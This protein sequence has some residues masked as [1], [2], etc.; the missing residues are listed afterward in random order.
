[1]ISVR[2]RSGWRALVRRGDV[3]ASQPNAAMPINSVAFVELGAKSL[4]DIVKAQTELL[5]KLQDL[6]RKW[7]DCL[8][9][10]ADI[11]SEFGVKFTTARSLPEATKVYQDFAERTWDMANENA[12]LLIADGQAFI[13]SSARMLSTGLPKTNGAA[14]GT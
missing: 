13:D 2:V 5:G 11:I 3:M 7:I 12:K 10:E 1:M 14:A 8:K 9:A 4:E 6:N